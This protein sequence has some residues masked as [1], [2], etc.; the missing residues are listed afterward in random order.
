[1]CQGFAGLMGNGRRPIY[2]ARDFFRLRLPSASLGRLAQVEVVAVVG[3]LVVAV[4]AGGG[5]SSASAS[6]GRC[7]GGDSVLTHPHSA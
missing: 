3:A 1:M 4:E 7:V 6:V 5:S 2:A